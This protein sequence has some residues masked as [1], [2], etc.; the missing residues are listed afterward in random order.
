MGMNLDVD[1]NKCLPRYSGN[2]SCPVR[3]AAH[4]TILALNRPLLITLD[5]SR[6]R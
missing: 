4:Q 2:F 3:D 6:A 1:I 5:D